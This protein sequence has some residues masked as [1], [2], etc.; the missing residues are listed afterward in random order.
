MTAAAVIGAL[1]L[2]AISFL[3]ANTYTACLLSL[4]GSP[5]S[6]LTQAIAELPSYLLGHGP[7]SLEAAALATG[8]VA[9]C[10]VWCAWAWSLTHGTAQRQGEERGSARWGT[11]REGR[12]FMDLTDH[13]RRYERNRNVLVVGGSGSGKTRG[14]FEPNVMQMSA[15]YL[16]TDPNGSVKVEFTF[17]GSLLAGHRTVAFESLALEG[18]VVATHEDIENE[19][20]SV[21]LVT[22]ASPDSPRASLA[23][24]GDTNN[25]V[26][27]ICLAVVAALIAT[28]TVLHERRGKRKGSS[29]SEETGEEDSE[30][31]EELREE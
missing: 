25:V 14:F 29:E 30:E 4:P 17:D 27:L 10:S 7:L 18:E 12:R 21:D 24:T 2:S 23:Q 22:P 16:I 26:P 31:E 19:G 8:L 5:V 6:N 9:A 15:N 3:A 11:V 28:L 20:Q 13:D 1:V